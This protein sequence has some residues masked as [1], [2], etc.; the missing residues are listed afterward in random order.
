MNR[1]SL[2]GHY[3]GRVEPVFGCD[4]GVGRLHCRSDD[5]QTYCAVGVGFTTGYVGVGQNA[6]LIVFGE[7]DEDFVDFDDTAGTLPR[8]VGSDTTEELSLGRIVVLTDSPV[9]SYVAHGLRS[10]AVD[11]TG[12]LIAIAVLRGFALFDS[13]RVLMDVLDF[14]GGFVGKQCGEQCAGKVC[15]Y[16]AGVGIV[17]LFDA[18]RA[19]FGCVVC[20]SF[21][22]VKGLIIPLCLIP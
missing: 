14:L 3:L 15:R 7:C 4:V 8:L 21:M 22:G 16:L 2:R 6:I 10:H 17:Q 13:P 9:E 12:E 20:N 1:F 19:N 18:D 5:T 11:R